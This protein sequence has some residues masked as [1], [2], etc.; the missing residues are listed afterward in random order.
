[1]TPTGSHLS[2]EKGVTP[3]KVSKHPQSTQRS[4]G[5][6]L[7]GEASA[8]LAGTDKIKRSV[9]AMAE[10]PQIPYAE[11][12]LGLLLALELSSLFISCF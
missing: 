10:D 11:Q 7:K 8:V 1:M 6:G 2:L 12:Q 3:F 4:G 5:P 9:E